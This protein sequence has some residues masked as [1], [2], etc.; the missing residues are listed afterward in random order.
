MLATRHVS[1]ILFDFVLFQCQSLLLL[2]VLLLVLLVVLLLLV[3]VL[4]FYQGCPL[5]ASSKSIHTSPL[6]LPILNIASYCAN[7]TI[8]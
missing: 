7:R 6:R 8:C 2:L 3:V 4:V 5:L 1:F